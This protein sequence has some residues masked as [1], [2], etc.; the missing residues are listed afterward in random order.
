MGQ[1]WRLGVPQNDYNVNRNIVR[2]MPAWLRRTRPIDRHRL[3]T[4]LLERCGRVVTSRQRFTFTTPFVVGCDVFHFFNTVASVR[5]PWVTT[6]ET[7][8]PRWGDQA[9]AV[10]RLGLRYLGSGSCR[11]L[12]AM[13]DAARHIAT[14]EW[15]ASLAPR[16]AGH[17]EGLTEVLLPPQEVLVEPGTKTYGESV[18]F[19]FVGALFYRK[20]GLEMLEAFRRLHQAGVRNWHLVVVGNL[21]Q[22]GDD[23]A[24]PDESSRRRA[25]EILASLP[26]RITHHGRLPYPRVLELLKTAH[27]SLLPTFADTFGYSVLEAQACGAVAITTN[28]R[29]LPEIVSPTTGYVVELPL[30][31]RRNAHTLP[32]FQRSRQDMVDALEAILRRCCESSPA[33]WLALASNATAGLRQRHDPAEHARRLEGVYRQALGAGVG[34]GPP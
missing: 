13:S 19:A 2:S 29:A 7:S 16:D 27:Y 25:F 34:S 15:Q 6:F 26:D 33:T 10:N 17:L 21:D 18:T 31:D 32:G 3:K 20:G 30:D 9:A 12:I 28:V 11:R 8:L 5:T 24:R 4:A 22:I 1:T 14:S 23:V